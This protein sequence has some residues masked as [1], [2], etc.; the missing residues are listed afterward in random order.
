MQRLFSRIALFFL[1]SAALYAT[2]CGDF[3]VSGSTLDHVTVTPGA[4]FLVKGENLQFTANAVNV[5]GT[6]SDITSSATWTSGNSQ[7]ATVTAGNV[8]GAN[9][10]ANG[11][12]TVTAAKGSVNGTAN[13]VVGTSALSATLTV[14]AP[15]SGTPSAP[16]VNSTTPVQLKAT[17]TAGTT[18]DLTTLVT[19]TSDNANIPV[20][21]TGLVTAT[22][23][24]TTSDSANITAT[25]NTK[26][27]SSSGTIKVTV[28]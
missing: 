12:T 6:S 26:S 10:T 14:T 18:I 11:N 20:S 28:Q 27:S 21:T 15:N 19:W 13:V 5:D 4:V 17:G 25:I 1:V 22:S 9:V 16:T 8:T 7:V 24:A 23:S 3:F 2:A